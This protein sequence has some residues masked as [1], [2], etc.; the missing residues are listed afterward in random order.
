MNDNTTWEFSRDGGWKR[1]PYPVDG[2]VDGEGL[3][4][5]MRRVGYNEAFILDDRDVFA[6]LDIF[7]RGSEITVPY[8]YY[9]TTCDFIPPEFGCFV[10]DFP[11]LLALAHD[12]YP[13]WKMLRDDANHYEIMTTLRKAFQLYHGHSWKDV[14]IDCDP[15]EHKRIREHLQR[16]K[17]NNH[18]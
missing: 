9:V 18:D 4:E 14:C 7:E 16:M 12:I 6:S 3:Y 13:L 15:N 5:W 11:D 8:R 1:I 17:R 10:E 2:G